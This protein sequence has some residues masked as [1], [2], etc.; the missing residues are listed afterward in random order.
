MQHTQTHS[1]RRGYEI[2][3]SK[4]IVDNI[5][6]LIYSPF[7]PFETGAAPKINEYFRS[8]LSLDGWA[9]GPRV[10]PAFKVDINAMKDKVGLTIQTGN[11][12]RAFYDLMKFQVLHLNDRIDVSVLILPS[13]DAAVALGSNIANFT[14]VTNELELFMD[15]VTVPCLVLSFDE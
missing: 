4:G 2:L 13:S 8:A 10:H 14:R 5:V 1:H 15:V 11:I 3:Q 7:I 12:T 9:L 6:G